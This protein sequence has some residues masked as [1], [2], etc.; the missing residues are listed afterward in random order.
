[1]GGREGKKGKQLQRKKDRGAAENRIDFFPNLMLAVGPIFNG[2]YGLV[3][4][5]L[6]KL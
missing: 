2:L 4:I 3:K 5:E 1:M 6:I